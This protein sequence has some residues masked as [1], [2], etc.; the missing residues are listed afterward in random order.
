MLWETQQIIEGRERAMRRPDKGKEGG[1]REKQRRGKTRRKK[2]WRGEMC[3]LLRGSALFISSSF[4]Y[5]GSQVCTCLIVKTIK[6]QRG[7]EGPNNA[8]SKRGE[9]EVDAIF[10]NALL[11][12]S[13]DQ[14][15]QV[16]HA[17]VI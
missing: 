16:R 1:K 6:L 13:S 2:G 4:S 10:G 7:A 3:K 9:T 12:H 8:V 5:I 14:V 11:L 17:D 15:S